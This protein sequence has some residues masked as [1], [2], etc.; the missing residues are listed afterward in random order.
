MTLNDI[1]AL[2][3]QTD[4]KLQLLRNRQQQSLLGSMGLD[5]AENRFPGYTELASELIMEERRL[6]TQMGAQS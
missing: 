1:R 3:E 5:A 2:P 6:L 4:P